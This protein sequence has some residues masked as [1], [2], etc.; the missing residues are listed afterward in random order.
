MKNRNQQFGQNR[1]FAGSGRRQAVAGTM[2]LDD[3][4]SAD[5]RDQ[6]LDWNTQVQNDQ[7]YYPD[8]EEQQQEWGG[9]GGLPPIAE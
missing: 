7:D 5:I 6:E 8:E 4:C 9:V 1:R 2:L 3:W